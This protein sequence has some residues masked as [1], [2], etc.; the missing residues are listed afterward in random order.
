MSILLYD[1]CSAEEDRRFS[2]YCWRTKMALRHKGLDFE[3][4]AVRFGTMEILAP[5]GFNRVPV[6]V[7]GETAVTESFDIACYLEDNYPDRPPLFAGDVG[8]GEARFLN[9]WADLTMG[10]SM[11]GLYLMGIFEHVH[12]DDRVYFRESREAR[13]GRKLE[14]VSADPDRIRETMYNTLAPLRATLSAQDFVCGDAPAYGDYIV[15]GAFMT[16]RTISTEKLLDDDDP[17]HAWRARMMELFGGF[18]AS[19]KGY[20]V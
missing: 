15:F 11:M 7:D 14:E 2:P 5:T 12:P 16:A 17:I 18:A 19:A 4:E 1:L 6:L 3:T 20:E 10:P 9:N 13:F 8:R